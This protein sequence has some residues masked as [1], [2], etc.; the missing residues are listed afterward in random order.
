MSQD[1]HIFSY[2][3]EKYRFR[4]IFEEAFATEQLEQ[5]LATQEKSALLER[6]Y[7][8]LRSQVFQDLYQRFLSEIA[9]RVGPALFVQSVPT[10]R[11]QK[12]GDKAVTFHVDEWSGHGK[13][14]QNFWLPLVNL[15]ALNTL[16]LIAAPLTRTLITR[17]Q[18][19][20]LGLDEFEQLCRT[21]AKALPI[22]YGDVIQFG[23]DHLHGTVANSSDA[24]RLSF[25][26]RVVR[27]DESPGNKSI[28]SFYR[29]YGFELQPLQPV[30]S[31]VY[32]VAGVAHLSHVA[33][34]TVISEY[35]AQHGLDVYMEN[36][37]LLQV[38]HYPVLAQHLARSNKPIVIFSA[39]CLPHDRQI[40]THLLSS[41]R[42]YSHD[43][44]FALEGRRLSELSDDY[45]ERLL[46]PYDD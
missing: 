15:N 23:N 37:E 45:F 38:P 14:I 17:F 7:Q 19:E 42:H 4:Q 36:N 12:P 20:H 8:V 29:P 1:Y 34:R 13:T 25:D 39:Q 10:L 16:S 27:R 35:C 26:F 32:C 28:R 3:T 40:R 18:T 41:M 43:I 46:T 24:V 11:I 21:Q 2:C 9:P 33:Q 31:I 44:H 30:I 6:G 22:C 5:Y